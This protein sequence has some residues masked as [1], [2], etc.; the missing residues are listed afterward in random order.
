M[1]TNNADNF[2]NPIT[3]ANGGTGSTSFTTNGIAYYNGTAL[4]NTSSTGTSGQVLISQ[5]GSYPLIWGNPAYTLISSQTSVSNTNVQFTSGITTAYNTYYII[6]TNGSSVSSTGQLQM[7]YSTNGGSS[8][9]NS[10]YGSNVPSFT[11]NS[12]TFSASS[13][14]TGGLNLCKASVE[15]PGLL[16][17][18]MYLF[19]VTSGQGCVTI[20][21]YVGGTSNQQ[22]GFING[23]CGNDGTAIN[24]LQ[25]L[26]SSGTGG[27]MPAG[28][29]FSLYGIQE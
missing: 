29:I 2:K 22:V 24:A 15:S 27:T 23:T 8:Y 16:F 1:A 14:S 5:G 4:T 19:N 28:T 3:V 10:G 25:F 13:A 12:S 6:I 17:V 11:Y 26:V 18:W 20:G 21:K 7:Q 9:A